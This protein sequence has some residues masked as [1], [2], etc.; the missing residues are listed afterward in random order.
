M[1]RAMPAS[2]FHE[3]MN[4]ATVDPFGNE[5][6][7]AQAA[8]IA[9]AAENSGRLVVSSLSGKS[10]ERVRPT[11]FMVKYGEDRP[12]RSPSELYKLIRAGLILGYGDKKS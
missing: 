12:E 7:D 3:W 6:G 4:Y 2:L 1:L 10:V 11:D 9:S 8:I 5:R